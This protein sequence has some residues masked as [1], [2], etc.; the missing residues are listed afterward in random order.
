MKN[1]PKAKDCEFWIKAKSINYIMIKCKELSK[2][3]QNAQC[4][5]HTKV[6]EQSTPAEY[7]DSRI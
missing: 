2:S 3:I 7:Q 4:I 1:E 5:I 6:H